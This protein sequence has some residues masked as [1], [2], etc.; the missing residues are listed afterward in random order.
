[1]DNFEK[2]VTFKKDHIIFAEGSP[3]Q[4]LYIVNY[5]E[6]GI[7][8]ENNNRLFPISTIGP[9]DFIGELSMFTEG[10]RTASA[11]AMENSELYLI[12]KTHVRQV[13]KNCPKWVTNIMLILA[14]R[15]R[16]TTLL[17]REHHITDDMSEMNQKLKPEN[18]AK[19]W[20]LLQDYKKKKGL[21]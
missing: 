11:I 13:L 1:M 21:A 3:S 9:K 17:L 5:G 16:S 20:K 18:L 2:P 12:Q 7:F 6:I 14:E 8:K 15:L 4:F 19:Y 10:V